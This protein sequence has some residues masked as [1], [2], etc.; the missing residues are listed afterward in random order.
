MIDGVASGITAA[1]I[2]GHVLG[3]F[4]DDLGKFDYYKKLA[5]QEFTDR[6]NELMKKTVK[7]TENIPSKSSTQIY[8]RIGVSD[9]ETGKLVAQ[10]DFLD[11]E[12]DEIKIDSSGNHKTYIGTA[13]NGERYNLHFSSDEPCWCIQH[14]RIKI[15]YGSGK[16]EI[17]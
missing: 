15:R 6:W 14:G 13:P 3:N 10:D 9:V 1:A 2:A 5:C 16:S 17:Q 12:F 4:G 7:R 8:D 11:L